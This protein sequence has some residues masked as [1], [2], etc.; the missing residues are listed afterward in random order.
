[1][2][3]ALVNIF[4][5]ESGKNSD[6][7]TLMGALSIPDLLYKNSFF[8]Y[9]NN[10]LRN[11]DLNFHWAKSFHDEQVRKAII[12]LIYGLERFYRLF[13]FNVI[14]YIK[15]NTI[16]KDKNIVKKMIYYK[17][18][19]RIFY[20]LLRSQGCERQI[21]AKIYIEEATEYKN[22]NFKEHI[23]DNLNIHSLYRGEN[24]W[25]KDCNYFTK[26]VEIGVELTD[27]I[28]GILRTIII[29]DCNSNSKIERNTLVLE[30]LKNQH[31]YNFICNIKY[32]EWVNSHTLDKIEFENYVKIF[33]SDKITHEKDNYEYN[34]IGYQNL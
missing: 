4:F 21:Q 1:M 14:N 11:T 8:Q 28:L 33:L 9:Y 19:E 32:F 5:D 7:P 26:N 15:P 30:L 34:M 6:R 24:F 27:L 10:L 12:K 18:P 16:N 25:I 20:G 3:D 22:I 31:F 29:N 13:D 2:K 23:K 17:L